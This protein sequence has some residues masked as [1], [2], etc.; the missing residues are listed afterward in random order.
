M[1]RPL[2]GIRVLE[3][4]QWWFVPAAGAILADWGA[5]VI[6][7]EHPETGDPQRGLVT[8]GLV[9]QGGFNFMWEQPNRGKKSVALDIRN[10]KGRELLYK[11]AERSDVFL[12][13]FCRRA[14]QARDRRGGHP[15]RQPRIIY[16]RG[17][18]RACAVP[19][20]NAAAT[21]RPAIGRAAV[22]ALRSPAREAKSRP[23]ARDPRSGTAWAA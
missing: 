11:L 14:A 6:K 9:P 16:A 19:T 12:T 7:I 15:A 21:T 23:S 4:A 10:E 8:S 18:A 17:R 5:E 2:D 20:P 1:E 13:S 3:V 22:W